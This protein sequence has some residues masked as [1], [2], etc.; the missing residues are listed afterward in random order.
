MGL[1]YTGCIAGALSRG[2]Y[3]AGLREAGLEDVSITPT[4]AAADGMWSAIIRAAKPPTDETA[5]R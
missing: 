3:E 2:E 1:R 4:H 5:N